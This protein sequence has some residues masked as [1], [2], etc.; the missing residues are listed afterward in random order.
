MGLPFGSGKKFTRPSQKS[1]NT[2]AG[3]AS[4]HRAASAGRP[5]RSGGLMAVSRGMGL[6]PG[7]RGGDAGRRPRSF[8]ACAHDLLATASPGY[9][10]LSG[11]RVARDQNVV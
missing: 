4:A 11:P 9:P 5:G 2:L 1:L 3:I 6:P 7:D 8:H 10:V